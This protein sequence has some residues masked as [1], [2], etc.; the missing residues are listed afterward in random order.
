MIVAG[1]VAISA[2]IY[3]DKIQKSDFDQLQSEEYQCN[4]WIAEADFLS[5]KYALKGDSTSWTKED[6]AEYERLDGLIGKY[7]ITQHEMAVKKLDDCT[8]DYITIQ[9]LI[10]RMVERRYETLSQ[11]DQQNYT[12]TYDKFFKNHC[13][14]VQDKIVREKA[15]L[16]F[17]KTRNGS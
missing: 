12:D 14:L 2:L 17:N 13:E 11:P 5:N 4:R 10:D 8:K 3:Y 7:C 9:S 15:F 16:D 1:I 6:I